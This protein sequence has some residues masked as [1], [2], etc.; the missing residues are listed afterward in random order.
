MSRKIKYDLERKRK[1]AERK[2]KLD[3][4]NRK[5]AEAKAADCSHTVQDMLICRH[6]RYYCSLCPKSHYFCCRKNVW[7]HLP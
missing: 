7:I 4:I 1:L 3:E 2:K 5:K 6:S